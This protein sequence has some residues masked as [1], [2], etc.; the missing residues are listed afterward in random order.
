MIKILITICHV[1]G[2]CEDHYAYIDNP[3]PLACVMTAQQEAADRGEGWVV[4]NVQCGR[5][6]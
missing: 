1:S 2:V 5:G 3:M 6:E 4:S